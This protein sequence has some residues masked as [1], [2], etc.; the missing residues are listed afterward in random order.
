MRR[1]KRYSATVSTT[2][3]IMRVVR[4][5]IVLLTIA[6]CAGAAAL[7][8]AML[9][10]VVGLDEYGISVAAVFALMVC[11]STAPKLIR[12]ANAAK[13]TPPA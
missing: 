12:W 5:V 2:E 3:S 9:L 8:T 10:K 4:W 1:L 6:V 11:W 7:L 13:R